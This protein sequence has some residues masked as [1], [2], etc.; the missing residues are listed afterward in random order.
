MKNIMLDV[1]ALGNSSGS[2]ILSIGAV[3]FEN[4][5]VMDEFYV[6]VDLDSCLKAGLSVN[7]RNL[8]WWLEESDLSREVLKSDGISLDRALALLSSSFDWRHRKVWCN[9]L[10]RQLPALT[11]AYEVCKRTVPWSY[12]NARDYPT[13]LETYSADTRRE[14]TERTE[15]P[16]HA[17]LNARAQA[18]TLTR[19]RNYRAAC[20]G[21][22][23][24]AVA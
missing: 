2:V 6:N 9:G 11:H 7:K 3:S 4:N 19:L 15:N 5:R 1:A 17:L 22:Q 14:M 10:D 18:T 24:S 12:F 21:S 13:V 20:R 8:M 16:C 23:F